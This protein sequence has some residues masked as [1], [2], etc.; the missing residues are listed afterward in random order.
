MRH[1]LVTSA[2]LALLLASGAIAGATDPVPAPAADPGTTASIADGKARHIVVSGPADI[3]IT[4]ERQAREQPTVRWYPDNRY[5][6][7]PPEGPA[8]VAETRW[9]DLDDFGGARAPDW[10]EPDLPP[11][12][13]T[14]HITIETV[15][16]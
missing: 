9:L 13:S 2:A 6:V 4:V 14:I 12:R 15:E 7:V 10:N 8:P 1:L 3:V 16:R 5:I 11:A